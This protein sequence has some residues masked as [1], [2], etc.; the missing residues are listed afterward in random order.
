[1]RGLRLEDT[2][3]EFGASW[4][5]GVLDRFDHERRRAITWDGDEL[6][7][8]V[9]VLTLGAHPER[10]WGSEGVL[11]FHGGADGSNYRLLLGRLREGQVTKQARVRQA[12]WGELA[13]SWPLP[14]Y[15]LALLTAAQCVARQ[16]SGVEPSLITPEEEPLAILGKPASAAVRGLLDESGVTLHTSSY[17]APGPDGWIDITPRHSA[18]AG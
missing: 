13:Q 1:M 18:H 6:P 15:D 2:A 10:E 8:D 17:G 11:T 4:H 5:R 14:L 9:L 12:N 16:L 7:Y 3:A